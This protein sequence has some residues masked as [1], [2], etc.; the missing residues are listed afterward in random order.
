MPRRLSLS[1]AKTERDAD[2]AAN[3]PVLGPF[4]ERPSRTN[5]TRNDAMTLRNNIDHMKT[6]LPTVRS[7]Y[8]AMFRADSPLL[9]RRVTHG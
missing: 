4:L 6:Q 3:T 5:L 9:H 7:Q 2:L 1:M 8:E